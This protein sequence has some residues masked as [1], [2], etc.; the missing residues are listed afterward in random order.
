MSKNLSLFFIG[1]A[2]STTIGLAHSL[3]YQDALA[4]QQAYC[5]NVDQGIWPDYKKIYKKVCK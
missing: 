5:E 3:S 2:L 4:E 1:V